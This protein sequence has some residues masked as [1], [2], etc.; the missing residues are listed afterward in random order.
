MVTNAVAT[1]TENSIVSWC[2]Q[3]FQPSR[4]FPNLISGGVT[5]VLTVIESV[6]YA[7]LIFSGAMA[8]DISTGIAVTLTSAAVAGLV[9]SLTSSYPGTIAVP[10]NKIA[11]ILAL[12][13][14]SI[15][16]TMPEGATHEQVLMTVIAAILLSTLATGLFMTA[17]GAF[18]LGGLIRFIPY[19]VVAG[20][21]A[22]TGWLLL[23]GSIKAM[24]GTAVTWSSIPG[25]LATP[26]LVKWL[27]G[28]AFAVTAHTLMRRWKHFLIMPGLLTGAFVLFY[29]VLF[30]TGTPVHEAREAGWLI[31]TSAS[32]GLWKF[33]TFHSVVQAEWSV[34]IAQAGSIA[35]ILLIGSVSILL[36]SS[37]LELASKEDLDLD[38]ELKSA[39]I[40][41]IATGL[42]GG[43]IGFTSLTITGLG[44]KMGVRSRLVGLVTVLSCTAV[45]F[46]GA[47]VLS[48]FPE[49]IIG[50]LLMFLGMEFLTEWVFETRHELPFSDWCIVIMILSVVGLFGFLYGVLAGV[51]AAIVVFVLNYSRVNVVKHE[52]TGGHHRSNVDRP[53]R[54]Q[55]LLRERGEQI[56]ILKLSGYIFF[57]T[58][59]HLLNQVRQRVENSQLDVLRFALLDFRDV[60]GIDSSAVISLVKMNQLAV[61]SGFAL[62]FT[63]LP[64]SIRTQLDKGRLCELEDR[65]C[66]DFA[67]TDHGIEWCEDQ[68]LISEGQQPRKE[69]IRSL[70]EHLE[71][72][73]PG[74]LEWPKLEKYLQR[75]EVP[76]GETLIRQ[77][78]IADELFF[79]ESGQVSVSIAASDG[80]SIRIRKMGEGTVVGELGLYLNQART[81]SVVTKEASVVYRLTRESLK[82]MEDANPQTAA[83]FH[84][85]MVRLLAQRLLH[86]DNTLKRLLE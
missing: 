33:L 40:A 72:W 55:R 64:D 18:G 79:I 8:S 56:Y 29:S 4:L 2:K 12:I 1:P 63:H 23:L 59:N 30:L 21:L 71:E 45:L 6:S 3:E 80:E 49:P 77:G 47:G 65:G 74:A 81:A 43:M 44:L 42:A 7:A 38:R 69:E 37:A 16:A 32:G 14:A 10:Q 62:V 84:R 35:S 51:V 20:F 78:D 73:V 58:A 5:S 53:P 67:D 27:P 19:P 66:L 22:G 41:N 25:L 15:V 54:Q 9:M 39:G 82:E 31:H 68:I 11:P 61:K 75:K 50:G 86:T 83:A 76:E 48:Y 24:T 36:N 52:L 85:F 70:A 17:L 28:L 13:A 26:V 60:S 34:V 57:G 46:L